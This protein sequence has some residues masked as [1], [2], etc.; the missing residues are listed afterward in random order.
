MSDY[1]SITF[2][3]ELIRYEAGGEAIELRWDALIGIAIETTDQGPFVED[4]FYIL[5]GENNTIICPS[6]AKGSQE[7]LTRLQQLHNFDNEAVIA[8]MTSTS[9]QTFICWEKKR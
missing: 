7:L 4:V 9:N 3:E 5:A 8:A 1:A 6:E 2:D